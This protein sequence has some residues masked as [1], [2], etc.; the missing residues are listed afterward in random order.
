MPVKS[1]CVI[2][3]MYFWA[4]VAD[5]GALCETKPDIALVVIFFFGGV[6]CIFVVIFLDAVVCTLRYAVTDP[7][8]RFALSVASGRM[9]EENQREINH[10]ILVTTAA[11]KT[12]SAPIDMA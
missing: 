11:V 4:G 7:G 12:A 1:V 2:D 5:I 3:V 6:C 8:C 9:L 10:S